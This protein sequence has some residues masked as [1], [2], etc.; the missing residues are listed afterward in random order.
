MVVEAR[1]LRKGYGDVLLMDDVNFTLPPG[2]I[3]GVIGPNGAGKTTLFRMLVGQ[4]QPDGGTL[5]LGE[6]VKIGYVDQ[7]REPGRRQ[8]CVEG[9]HRRGRRD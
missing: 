1:K 3:V 4:E 9:D 7:S 8:H 2:G 6:T 5:R